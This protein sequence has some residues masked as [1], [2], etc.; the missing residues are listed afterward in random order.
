MNCQLYRYMHLFF[1]FHPFL[2]CTFR[3]WTSSLYPTVV[4]IKHFTRDRYLKIWSER[5]G[6][7]SGK[8]PTLDET[9]YVMYSYGSP[10]HGTE[11]LTS[12]PKDG[13]LLWFM[14]PKLSLTLGRPVVWIWPTKCCQS[15]LDIFFK[16]KSFPN[17]EFYTAPRYPDMRCFNPGF[18][19]T[20]V[21][22][23]K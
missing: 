1:I 10:I 17:R 8:C 12:P 2:S 3:G 6:T 13:I 5:V 22:I 19:Y 23:I 15:I 14:Y 21:D 11:G 16:W 20:C 7:V 18:Q 4:G 9:D